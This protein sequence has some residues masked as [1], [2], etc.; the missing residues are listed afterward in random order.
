M[1]ASQTLRPPARPSLEEPPQQAKGEAKVA[2]QMLRPPARP[3]LEEPPQQA[4]GEAKVE[5]LYICV[6]FDIHILF[7]KA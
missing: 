1:V 4:K 7:L 3:S 2:S 6:Y 5:R